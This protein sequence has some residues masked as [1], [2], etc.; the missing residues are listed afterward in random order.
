MYETSFHAIPLK[1]SAAVPRSS[2]WHIR[3]IESIPQPPWKVCKWPPDTHTWKP[4]YAKPSGILLRRFE[5][6]VDV[7]RYTLPSLPYH[8]MPSVNIDFVYAWPSGIPP[9]DVSI[10]VAS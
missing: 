1:T 4:R 10:V 8:L 5:A 7:A 6:A 2:H 9:L 3:G